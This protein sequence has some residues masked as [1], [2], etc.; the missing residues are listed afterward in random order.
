MNYFVESTLLLSFGVVALH[1]VFLSHKSAAQS[2][3]MQK[4]SNVNKMQG[5][6][7]EIEK[8]NACLSVNLCATVPCECVGACT[9]S[10]M[11]YGDLVSEQ[12]LL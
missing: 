6:R 12:E 10:C 4:I 11:C 5:N 3:N 8:L 7:G 9:Q 2:K 1:E